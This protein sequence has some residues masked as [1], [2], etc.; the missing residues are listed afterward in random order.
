MPSSLLDVEFKNKFQNTNR[1]MTM[2]LVSLLIIISVI[3]W[4][5]GYESGGQTSVW[6]GSIL[7][8]LAVV[9]YKLPHLSFILTKKKFQQGQNGPDDEHLYADW[10]T[11]KQ[12]MQRDER[13]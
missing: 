4:M 13:L 1:M 7:M 10:P 8:L 11:F 3:F 12:S 9:F 2:G 6:I 5:L